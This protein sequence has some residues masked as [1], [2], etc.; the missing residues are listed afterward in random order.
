V[1]TASGA[2]TETYLFGVVQPARS[3]VLGK[4]V[5]FPSGALV[6]TA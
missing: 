6:V 3:I 5:R 2:F 1:N 4:R